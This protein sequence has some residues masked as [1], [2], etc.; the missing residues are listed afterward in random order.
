M[1]PEIMQDYYKAKRNYKN[2]HTGVKPTSVSTKEIKEVINA[3]AGQ[4]LE[5]S[6]SARLLLAKRVGLTKTEVAAKAGSITYIYNW[7]L[8][9]FSQDY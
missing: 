2:P 5:T 7:P 4:K 3:M 6:N 9:P 8:Q 1:K